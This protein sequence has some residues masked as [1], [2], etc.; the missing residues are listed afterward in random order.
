MPTETKEPFLSGWARHFMKES[1]EAY[2]R[3]RERMEVFIDIPGEL[4]C[5]HVEALLEEI[6]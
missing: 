6:R 2:W 3:P 5:E 1:D 4:A